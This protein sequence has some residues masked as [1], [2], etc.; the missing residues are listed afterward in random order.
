MAIACRFPLVDEEAIRGA[1]N[2]RE[3]AYDRQARLREVFQQDAKLADKEAG[4]KH[5]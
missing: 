3:K 1:Y 5:S 2:R 4:M